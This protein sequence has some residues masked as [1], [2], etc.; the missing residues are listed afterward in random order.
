VKIKNKNKVSIILWI[1]W[2]W[3]FI[4]LS[5]AEETGSYYKASRYRDNSAFEGLGL[6]FLIL[7]L[8]QPLLQ[9]FGHSVNTTDIKVAK[10]DLKISESSFLFRVITI[11]DQ[12]EDLPR[13][14]RRS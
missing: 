7:C 1:F 14:F 6:S 4:P 8:R 3:L 2:L 5:F 12:V 13:S 9:D 11:I 10:N